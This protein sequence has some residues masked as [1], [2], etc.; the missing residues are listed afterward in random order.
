MKRK[1]MFIFGMIVIV[2]SLIYV[3]RPA[4]HTPPYDANL[5]RLAETP[6][7]GYCSG[8]AF[9]ASEGVGNSSTAARCRKGSTRSDKPDMVRVQVSFCKAVTDAGYDG[10]VQQC[11]QILS[12]EQLWPTYDG[13]LTN[14]WNRARPYPSPGL[15]SSVPQ[16][17]Q[18]RTGGRNDT[19]HQGNFR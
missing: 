5:V 10:G 18:S 2:I 13:A 9:W 7:Q 11:L 3:A 15:P 16:K 8:V 6:R 1:M 4:G 17:D 14:Q 19:T 12:S